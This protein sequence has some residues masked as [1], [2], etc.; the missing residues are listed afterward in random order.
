MKGRQLKEGRKWGGEENKNEITN[1]KDKNTCSPQPY[2]NLL[3]AGYIIFIPTMS[4]S[5]ITV[6]SGQTKTAQT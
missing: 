6:V 3:N 2:N 1:N 5:R 4:T